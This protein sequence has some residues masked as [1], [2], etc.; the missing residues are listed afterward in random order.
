MLSENY[1][2]ILPSWAFS[3]AKFGDLSNGQS[4]GAALYDP[5]EL[6]SARTEDSYWNEIQNL[7]V[8]QQYLHPLLVVYWAYRLMT[9]NVSSRAAIAVRM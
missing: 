1:Q 2:K 6:E 8:E 5:H 3:T 7:L 9:W 4:P